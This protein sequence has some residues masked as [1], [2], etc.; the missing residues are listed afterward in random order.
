V[1]GQT[2]IFLLRLV[3]AD[4][5]TRRAPLDPSARPTVGQLED[6]GGAPVPSEGGSSG[7]TASETSPAGGDRP[8][9]TAEPADTAEPSE[10]PGVGDARV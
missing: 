10:R 8:G 5:R 1:S 7:A 3:A 2:I 6:R 9:D 4:R